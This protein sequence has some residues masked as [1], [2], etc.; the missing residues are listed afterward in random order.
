M[1]ARLRRRDAGTADPQPETALAAFEPPTAP[2][3]NG[4][5]RPRRVK[6]QRVETPALLAAD[7]ITVQFGGLTAVDDVSLEVRQ[8][9]IVGLIG[10]N[11]AGKTTLFNAIS[12]LNRPTKGTVSLHGVDV[13]GRPVHARAAAGLARTFQVLQLFPQLDV[14][15]NLL[16]GTHLH[17]GNAVLP[18]LALTRG[19]V[20]AELHAADRAQEVIDM[21]GLHDVTHHS[22]SGLPFGMLR[23]VELARALVTGAPLIMLD[24][25]ASGLDNAETDR[26]SELLVRVR[27]EFN[28]TILVIEHDVRMVTALTHYMYVIDRGRLIAQGTPSEIQQ[29]PEVIAA[30]LGTPS[31]G[32][33]EGVPA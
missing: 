27:E 33:R 9:E 10:P 18:R 8:G 7:G 29:N 16:V 31:T 14:F 15:E 6:P 21:L 26:L 25:P 12:G 5:H 20:L 23:M 1:P 3:T 11:G 30:Y 13:T 4:Q 28:V 32:P 24:E 2:S 19:A 17:S 22:V